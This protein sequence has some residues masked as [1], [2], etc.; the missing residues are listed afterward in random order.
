[1]EGF[2]AGLFPE[3]LRHPANCEIITH[4][5]NAQKRSRSSMSIEDLLH[6]IENY[7]GEWEEQQLCSDLISLYRQHIIWNIHYE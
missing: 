5:E 7:M 3:L 4:S 6:T 2:T 1:M